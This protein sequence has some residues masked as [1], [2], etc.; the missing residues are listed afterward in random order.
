MKI[1]K[2]KKGVT[3]LGTAGILLLFMVGALFVGGMVTVGMYG[4]NHGW[5]G[6]GNETT[7]SVTG[8]VTDPEMCSFG[9]TLIDGKVLSKNMLT[10]AAVDPTFTVWKT[11]P[12]EFGNPRGSFPTDSENLADT[13]TSSSG[14]ATLKE[15]PVD[16]PYYVK[17][18]LSSYG[19]VFF[20]ATNAEKGGLFP[21]SQGKLTASEYNEAPNT[22]SKSFIGQSALAMQ[23]VSLGIT[24]NA[25][26]KEVTKYVYLPTDDNEG[27]AIWKATFYDALGIKTDSDNDNTYDEG[28]KKLSLKI[29]DEPE[30]VIFEPAKG[31]NLIDSSTGKYEYVVKESDYEDSDFYLD[32]NSIP[33]KVYVKANVYYNSN[34]TLSTAADDE[35]L[36]TGEEIGTISF[37]SSQ[38]T[39]LGDIHILVS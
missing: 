5:F 13:F 4:K 29:G 24:V 22:I 12:E 35:L 3:G 14:T 33:V 37:L 15:D 20:E 23:N 18:T 34:E 30:K 39:D 38:A 26:D 6:G 27:V 17:A 31:I 10:G 36:G 2:D 7:L 9:G 16:A 25:T 11:K 21:C 1:E 32:G 19:T 8:A 28:V